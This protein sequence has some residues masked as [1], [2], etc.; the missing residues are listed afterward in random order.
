MF[1]DFKK[2]V[3]RGNVMD[4]AVG[5]IIGA[6]FGGV[7]KS[8]VDDILMP[9]LGLLMGK[10][11][12]SNLFINLSGNEGIKSVAQAKAAGI[13]TINYGLFLN[14][15][16]NF[17]IVV[18][19]IFMVVQRVNKMMPKQEA[20]VTTK[21]CPHCLNKVPMAAT[22]CGFCTSELSEK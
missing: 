21:D 1:A 14:T 8:L 4:L 10:V 2:F 5:V 7:V 18:F 22:K 12:F 6:A 11:D 17:L 20:P 13:A 15:V 3:M 9:P 16:V 19:A